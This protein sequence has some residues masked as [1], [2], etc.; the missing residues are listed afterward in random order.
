MSYKIRLSLLLLGLLALCPVAA[1]ELISKQCK[2]LTEPDAAAITIKHA[3]GLL[4]KISKDGLADSYLFGTIH[5]PDKE[6][7]DLPKIVEQSLNEAEQ[8]IMEV[9]PK[10]EALALLFQSMIYT[11]GQSLGALLDPKIYAETK[12][13]LSAYQI[14]AQTAS[15]LKPWSAFLTISYPPNLSQ[16]PPLDLVLLSLAQKNGAAI[17]S[18]ETMQ[19]QLDVFQQF[20]VAEQVELLTDSV[21]HYDLVQKDFAILKAFYL[22]QDLVG[23]YRY[24]KRY[25]YNN[26]PLYQKFMKRLLADRNIKMAERLQPLLKKGKSFIAIGALHLPGKIGILTLLEQQGYQVNVI[27]SGKMGVLT[28]LEKQGYQV[29]VIF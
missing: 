15:M 5:I 25:S 13:I 22:K 29:N 4:W 23:L 17:A 16:A 11:D 10:P 26:Q 18:L 12:K 14:D 2:P 21:C 3:K 19:E 27:F 8:F 28:L 6:V 24:V 9:V 20:S 1:K 7:T